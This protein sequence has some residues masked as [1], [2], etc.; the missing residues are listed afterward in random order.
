MAL[1]AQNI[2]TLNSYFNDGG[3]LGTASLDQ[4]VERAM[5]ELVNQAIDSE[6]ARQLFSAN[7]TFEKTL[8]PPSLAPTVFVR[9]TIQTEL[10]EALYSEA[11]GGLWSSPDPMGLNQWVNSEASGRTYFIAAL[12]DTPRT[13][14]GS[15]VVLAGEVLALLLRIVRDLALPASWFPALQNSNAFAKL[16]VRIAE[17]TEGPAMRRAL[18]ALNSQASGR[19]GTELAK[20]ATGDLDALSMGGVATVPAS[21]KPWYRS[22]WSW[23]GGV[24]GLIGGVAYARRR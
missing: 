9:P 3:D 8:N 14:S 5:H 2:A 21:R 19:V 20:L 22:G 17:S 12:G 24:T 15:P 16:E 7:S 23:V 13:I 6:S 10:L 18:L 4:R 1:A 11:S